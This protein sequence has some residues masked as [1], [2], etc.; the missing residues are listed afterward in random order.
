M[1]KRRRKYTAPVN[2]RLHLLLQHSDVFGRLVL[3]LLPCII[4]N[5]EIHYV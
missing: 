4:A 2:V 3:V 5:L 1:S